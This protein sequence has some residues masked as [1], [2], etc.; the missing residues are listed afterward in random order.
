MKLKY[1]RR[2]YLNEYL[3]KV[4]T[5]E[6]LIEGLD[7][8][9]L[10]NEKIPLQEERFLHNPIA[11]PKIEEDVMEI[12]LLTCFPIKEEIIDVIPAD[13]EANQEVFMENDQWF[14][15]LPT[16][17]RDLEVTEEVGIQ[18]VYKEE[19]NEEILKLIPEE[20][21][22]FEELAT[23]IIVFEEK[24]EE[25]FIMNQDFIQVPENSDKVD[26]VL[27]NYIKLDENLQLNFSYQG[28]EDKEVIEEAPKNFFATEE[29]N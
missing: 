4:N 14:Q 10:K 3:N 28:I 13:M 5:F 16:I 8:I 9:P 17:F 12:T 25:D 11:I 7:K 15:T 26:F 6:T 20:E 27:L 18:F 22:H 23:N 24:I 19:Y 2:D 1:Q 29:G 21:F